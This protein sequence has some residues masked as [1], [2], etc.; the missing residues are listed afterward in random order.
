MPKDLFK[1]ATRTVEQMNF[2]NMPEVVPGLAP[3]W[4]SPRAAA[5]MSAVDATHILLGA[6]QDTGR[7]TIKVV[8][9]DR[10]CGL[11]SYEPAGALQH[12]H[13]TL[14]ADVTMALWI[15]SK[16]GLPSAVGL[17]EELLAESSRL[18][19]DKYGVEVL[20]NGFHAPNPFIDEVM[21]AAG[22]KSAVKFDSGEKIGGWNP[23][24]QPYVSRV[25]NGA[26]IS[27]DPKQHR[28]FLTTNDSTV[29]VSQLEEL[30][31]EVNAHAYSARAAKSRRGYELFLN[32][33]GKKGKEL[34][35][36]LRAELSSGKI[37]ATEAIEQAAK[38][39]VS[40]W[41]AAWADSDKATYRTLAE[42]NRAEIEKLVVADAPGLW[43]SR[44][45]TSEMIERLPGLH[46]RYGELLSETM[47]VFRELKEEQIAGGHREL[48]N[49]L[50]NRWWTKRVSVGTRTK[51][52]ERKQELD[53]LRNQLEQ[54]QGRAAEL[55]EIARDL[56]RERDVNLGNIAFGEVIIAS[57]VETLQKLEEELLAAQ[58][59]VV[60]LK[61]ALLEKQKPTGEKAEIEALK[62]KVVDL[63]RR[64]AAKPTTSKEDADRIQ[65]LTRENRQLVD[66]LESRY[67][68]EETTLLFLDGFYKEAIN[69]I[70]GYILRTRR[71]IASPVLLCDAALPSGVAINPSWQDMLE[72]YEGNPKRGSVEILRNKIKILQQL[73]TNG[74]LNKPHTT[75]DVEIDR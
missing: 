17:I 70:D 35:S 72:L 68:R 38:K 74:L 63:E 41:K 13:G 27:S 42:K 31:V 57:Q 66:N 12:F 65:D 1:S 75:R 67:L 53:G 32:T 26:W 51:E 33:D 18:V 59:E 28:V 10:D 56:R 22:F 11:R 19:A 45:F 46:P 20:V 37:T 3:A 55:E 21:V 8:R 34:P 50:F 61:A 23:H 47:T 62:A 71:S 40:R 15:G 60:S 6:A 25:K 58:T 49:D 39:E 29:S 64:L 7:T 5:S 44:W 69:Q 24:I 54:Q 43:L 30:G 4:Y 36:D 73:I 14:R 48:F 9:S 2:A 16:E 52:E